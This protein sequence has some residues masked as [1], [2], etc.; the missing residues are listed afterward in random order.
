M[1]ETGLRTYA[2]P[3]RYRSR[4]DGLTKWAMSFSFLNFK[5]YILI[6]DTKG[7]EYKEYKN[8]FVKMELRVCW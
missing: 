1:A 8:V 4:D 7:F 2:D 5:N 3:A 6:D